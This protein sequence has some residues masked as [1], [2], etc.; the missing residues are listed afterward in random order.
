[1]TSQLN[2]FFSFQNTLCPTAH[3]LFEIGNARRRTHIHIHKIAEG[4]SCKALSLYTTLRVVQSPF[5]LHHVFIKQVSLEVTT[6]FDTLYLHKI[7]TVRIRDNGTRLHPI[8]HPNTHCS[9][10]QTI[11]RHFLPSIL[12]FRKITVNRNR[13]YSLSTNQV[14]VLR[15]ITQRHITVYSK[16]IIYS[17]SSLG[18]STHDTYNHN[19]YIEILKRTEILVL[20][21]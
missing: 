7:S 11:C 13:I 9:S 18:G 10:P 14:D 20:V 16:K 5:T 4:T 6:V 1:M 19:T 8:L 12:V 15:Y 2:I 17:N 3:T 21:P